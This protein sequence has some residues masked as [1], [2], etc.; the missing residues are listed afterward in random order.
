MLSHLY[1]PW[2]FVLTAF[3]EL[4]GEVNFIEVSCSPAMICNSHFR[5]RFLAH[6]GKVIHIIGFDA[7][8]AHLFVKRLG[9]LYDML[10]AILDIVNTIYSFHVREF[11]LS[12]SSLDHWLFVFFLQIMT[13][14][15]LT[16]LNSIFTFYATYS[17]IS[18]ENQIPIEP[19]LLQILWFIFYISY[20]VIMVSEG[21][22]LSSKVH[23][24]TTRFVNEMSKYQ[25]MFISFF[26]LTWH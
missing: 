19:F 25:W 16:A 15:I 4:W 6:Q 1:R 24:Y 3:V 7:E 8:E 11:H 20:A 26:I 9:R 21:N 5:N 2:M 12:S 18:S 13:F 10:C 14:M 23:T 17:Y 22:R